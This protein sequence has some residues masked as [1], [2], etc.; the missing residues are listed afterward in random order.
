MSERHLRPII[1]AH[2]GLHRMHPENS[3]GAFDAAWRAG[4]AWCE[5]D[6]Q[7]A[8]SGKLIIIHDA[9]L[10]RTTTGSG[11]VNSFEEDELERLRLKRADGS[12]GGQRLPALADL[13]PLM[14]P[15][16][17]LLLEIKPPMSRDALRSQL[18][19]LHGRRVILQSFH[20]EVVEAAQ[21]IVK[22]TRWLTDK[23]ADFREPPR[24]GWINVRHDLVDAQVLASLRDS[25]Y[26]VGVWTPNTAAD[27]ARVID[28][29]VDMII[30]GEPLLARDLMNRR[31]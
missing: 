11:P 20:R 25:R 15:E 19:G 1:V 14:P 24:C 27:L 16:A 21:G 26:A 4:I 29:G 17:R 2:R 12:P 22:E 3:L 8:R 13:L 18:A 30:T 6:V 7:Q 31:G 10:D 28:L 23:P 9:T 5:C